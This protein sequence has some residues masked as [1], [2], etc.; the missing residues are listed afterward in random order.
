MAKIV[1]V[2]RS[3]VL[4]QLLELGKIILIDD[5]PVALESER[6][7]TVLL[8]RQLRDYMKRG[9]CENI[10]LIDLFDELLEEIHNKANGMLVEKFKFDGVGSIYIRTEGTKKCI[11]R[12]TLR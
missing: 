4:T 9:L 10:E 8:R 3:E 7:I 2:Y 1:V 11:A 12:R 6:Y 5:N